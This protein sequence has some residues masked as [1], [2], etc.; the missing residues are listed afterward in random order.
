MGLLHFNHRA[1]LAFFRFQPSYVQPP[2]TAYVPALIAAG[3]RSP[4]LHEPHML[5]YLGLPLLSFAALG[6]YLLG[7]DRR[8]LASAAALAVSLV[9]AVYVGG[10][11]G[12]WTA[13]FRGF[14][15]VDPRFVEGATATWA[16]V[17]A[18]RGALLVTTWLAKLAIVGP[19]LQALCLVGRRGVPAWAPFVAAAGY[20]VIV[21]FW[22]QDNWMMIGEALVLAAMVPMGA[23][24][25]RVETPLATE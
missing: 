2:A 17:T 23:E 1:A 3:N 13:F 25:R 9:G 20:G 22:D 7:R 4:L 24:L 10:L 15:D 8:P 16:A 5:G 19:A 11:F 6:L 21:V 18:P 12:A 14:G